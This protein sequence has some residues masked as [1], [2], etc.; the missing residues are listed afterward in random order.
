[1][2]CVCSLQC[3]HRTDLLHSPHPPP[4][5]MNPDLAEFCEF[6]IASLFDVAPAAA[7]CTSSHSEHGQREGIDTPPY[8]PPPE[9][10]E[11]ASS[12]KEPP[13][14]VEFIVSHP[15]HARSSSSRLIA[16]PPDLSRVPAWEPEGGPRVATRGGRSSQT[17]H[18]RYHLPSIILSMLTMSSSS[19]S[20][21]LCPGLRTLPNSPAYLHRPSKSSPSIAFK[22]TLSLSKR[23]IILTTSSLPELINALSQDQHG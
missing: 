14:L 18:G 6:V 11:V 23:N 10:S 20:I 17:T 15:H 7:A 2:A 19:S 13:L 1:M 16:N 3:I 4:P 5:T 21:V 22:S 9:G 12:R 8:T